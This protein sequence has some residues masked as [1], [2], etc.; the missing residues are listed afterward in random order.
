MTRILNSHSASAFS[1]DLSV[2][3]RAA[4]FHFVETTGD[5]R[6]VTVPMGALGRMYR[7]IQERLRLDPQLL[8]NPAADN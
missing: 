1:I 6:V 8:D 2:K 7:D 5:V 4:A 3:R